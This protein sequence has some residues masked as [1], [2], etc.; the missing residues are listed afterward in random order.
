MESEFPPSVE[1]SQSQVYESLPWPVSSLGDSLT[2]IIWI[3]FRVSKTCG[4]KDDHSSIG[5]SECLLWGAIKSSGILQCTNNWNPKYN[6]KI[7]EVTWIES[8]DTFIWLWKSTIYTWE[9]LYKNREYSFQEGNAYA[10]PVSY[11]WVNLDVSLNPSKPLSQ[12]GK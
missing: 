9:N 7:Q 3:A 12:M 1:P 10:S 6:T 2:R 11:S 4:W 8:A 5:S